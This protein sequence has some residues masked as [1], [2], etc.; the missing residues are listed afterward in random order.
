MVLALVFFGQWS[1]ILVVFLCLVVL[2]SLI[3]SINVKDKVWLSGFVAIL[4]VAL[5]SVLQIFAY[6]NLAEQL[7][8]K[9]AALETMSNNYTKLKSESENGRTTYDDL[10]KNVHTSKSELDDLQRKVNAEFERTVAEIKRIY[11]DISDEELDRRVNAI[12]RKAN[13]NLQNNVFK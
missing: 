12:V 4:L 3:R 7:S 13:R 11:A 8:G 1:S 10:R 2:A 5:I 6:S 9:E